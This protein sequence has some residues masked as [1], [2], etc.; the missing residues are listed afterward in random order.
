MKDLFGTDFSLMIG[1]EPLQKIPT[2]F[3]VGAKPADDLLAEVIMTFT[4]TLQL[5]EPAESKLSDEDIRRMS[6]MI[7]D[8][9]MRE[10]LGP[11]A[12]SEFS[13]SLRAAGAKV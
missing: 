4:T 3:F 7:D 8:M 1:G 5:D 10:I 11:Y 13:E 6:K 12:C 2:S 9:V